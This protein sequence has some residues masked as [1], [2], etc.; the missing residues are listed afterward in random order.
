MILLSFFTLPRPP[1]KK[2]KRKGKKKD[3]NSPSS[4]WNNPGASVLVRNVLDL[5]GLVYWSPSR[6]NFIPC[7]QGIG[8]T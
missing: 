7:A 8:F 2:N 6:S 1:K 5:E 4:T 3:E